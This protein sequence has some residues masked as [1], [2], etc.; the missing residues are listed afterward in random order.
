M[1]SPDGRG[2]RASLLYAAMPAVFVLLWSS[3]FIIAKLALPYSP[4][5]VF[6]LMRFA[7]V[8]AVMLPLASA[9]RA[10]W[11]R[12]GT[13]VA[14]L[15]V[16][17]ALLHGGYLA[18]VFCAIAHGMSAGLTALIV[19]TQPILTGLGGRLIGERVSPRQWLGL[20]L[21]FGGV[22]L[23]LANRTGGA[24]VTGP[25][26]ALALL[27][28]AGITGGT[29]YQKRYCGAMDLRTGSIV[30]FA[31]AALVLLPFALLTETFEVKWTGELLF[32]LAW[33]VLVMSLGAISLLYLL[34]RRGAAT[35][36]SSLFY[37]TPP[38][39]AVMAFF[40]FGETLS[41]Q[42]LLGLALTV[43]G[44]AMVVKK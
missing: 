28:L 6:L 22:A 41:M 7:L 23:V 10:P 42:A 1:A 3:G 31:A 39:T 24:A 17:G 44:V 27:G 37:L 33:S 19:G 9:L 12:D 35:R 18:G 16:A 20:M 2:E 29:L 26:A 43:C 34:I 30:Q 38:T 13:Q 4:P 14:H 5:L 8:L 11:P 21:G 25:G 40:I 36:V 15:A 32:S